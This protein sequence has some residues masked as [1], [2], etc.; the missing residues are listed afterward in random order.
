MVNILPIIADEN[1]NRLGVLEEYSSLIWTSRYYTPG[2]FE[3]CANV[4]PKS[5]E[6]LKIDNFVI[7]PDDE[8]VGIIED[9]VIQINADGQEMIT[10]K[11]RFLSSILGRRIVAE[12]TNFVDTYV[13]DAIA[14]LI[15]QNIIEPRN[16]TRRIPGFIMGSSETL[17]EQITMQVTGANLLD[18]V[19]ELCQA[20]GLGHKIILTNNNKFQ[21]ELYHG[22]DRSY[23]QD[24]NPH[25]V[26]SDEYDNIISANYEKNQ[27]KKVTSVLVAGE[28]EGTSRYT[29]WV[30]GVPHG[31]GLKLYEA[32]KDARDLSSNNGEIPITEYDQML[33]QRALEV[34]SN[35]TT[36]FSSEVDFKTIEYKKDVYLGDIVTVENKRWGISMNCRLVEV[37]ESVDSTGAYTIN[38]TFGQ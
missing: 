5:I 27:Q 23:D 21:F 7:R 20:Y 9:I 22:T 30:G 13:S 11:G 25:V 35:F 32:Y 34:L 29:L 2:D 3:I 18:K 6:F 28:G 31:F 10:A 38:P 12:Q 1:L 36:A 8:N 24:V 16:R 37:I 14:G 33:A 17:G 26:F 4:T 15:N 19:N